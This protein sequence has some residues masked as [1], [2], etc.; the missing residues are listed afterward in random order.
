MTNRLLAF[1][2]A[3]RENVERLKEKIALIINYQLSNVNYI[4]IF[5][6]NI[7]KV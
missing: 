2:V 7:N 1:F 4:C 6:E 5:A 3:S